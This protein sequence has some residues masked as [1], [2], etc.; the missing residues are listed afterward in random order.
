MAGNYVII[1]LDSSP[2][3]TIA[4][5]V[6][7]DG[8][9]LALRLRVRYN[10]VGGLW[11]MTV[12]DK[13]GNLLLDSIPLVTGE[14]PAGDI[15]AQYRYLGLGTAVLVNVG[16]VPSYPSDVPTGSNLGSNGGYLLFWGDTAS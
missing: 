5:T 11:H 1:P 2:D 12:F 14:Y 10:D 13:D 8:Q 9:N 15:L 6:P 3:Q 16:A 4:V 7:V